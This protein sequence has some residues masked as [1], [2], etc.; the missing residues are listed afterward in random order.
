MST[1]LYITRKFRMTKNTAKNLWRKCP[2]CCNEK[3][4]TLCSIDLCPISDDNLPTHF[5]VVTCSKCGFCFDDLQATQ[6]D[7]DRYYATINKYHVDGTASS[8]G[9][10]AKDKDRYE[11]IIS[12]INNYIKTEDKILDIGA[13]KGGMLACLKNRG[14]NN[15]YAVEPSAQKNFNGI[16]FYRSI[17]EL[18]DLGRQFDVILC[19]QVLEHVFDLREFIKLIKI[20]CKKDGILYIEIPDA[21]S[22]AKGF[23]APF[24]YFDREHINHFTNTSIKNLFLIS[25]YTLLCSSEFLETY[26]CISFVFKNSS[27]KNHNFI[28]ENQLDDIADYI[29][30][31]NVKDD[32]SHLRDLSPPIILWG[33]GA[34]LRRIFLKDEFPQKISAIIDQNRGMRGE[35]LNKIPIVTLDMLRQEEYGMATVII[36]SS[37]YKS[38]IQ[39]LLQQMNYSGKV[40]TAF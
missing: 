21:A 26:Y 8:G 5:D 35:Y 29:K 11:K 28:S 7:F 25:G 17:Q 6:S 23:I 31:S 13:G 9:Y 12:F 36:T 34:Y 2:I 20:L 39:S 24:H 14:F 19:S 1:F 37:L 16:T 22:Y 3:G 18:F 38:E 30:I 15:L 4:E 27:P 33:L 32:I 10:T 40:L